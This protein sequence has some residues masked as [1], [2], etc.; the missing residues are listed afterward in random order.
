MLR[1]NS[2]ERR[3]HPHRGG[4]LKSRK[5]KF[6]KSAFIGVGGPG[7]V[8]GIAAGYELDGS[9][10]ES[11]WRARFSAPVQ[12]GPGAHPGSCTMGTGPF[13]GVKIDRSV[14]LTPHTF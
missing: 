7:R 8:D 13:P 3:Y 14:T 11:R 12:T 2:E 4:S 5:M 1:N 6:S 10:F 9:G